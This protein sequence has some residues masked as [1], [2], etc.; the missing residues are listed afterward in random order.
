MRSGIATGGDDG[1]D[2]VMQSDG[3]L[4]IYDNGSAVW[5]SRAEP[6]APT[7]N[8]RTTATSSSIKMGQRSGTDPTASAGGGSGGGSL[9][10]AIVSIT[11]AKREIG[12]IRQRPL[13]GAAIPI[14]V[15]GE[16]TKVAIAARRDWG[17][18]KLGAPISRH[19]CGSKPA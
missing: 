10:N 19:G 3:N 17:V 15:I 5:N 13:T 4:V 11:I 1:A 9:G 7:C 6:R 18:V 2:T 12:Q 8:C 14:P 16:I